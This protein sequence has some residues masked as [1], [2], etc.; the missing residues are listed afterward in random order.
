ML[1]QKSQFKDIAAFEVLV[2]HPETGQTISFKHSSEHDYMIFTDLM[3]SI[4][5]GAQT[6]EVDANFISVYN[7]DQ[8]CYNYFVQRLLGVGIENE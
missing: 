6:D 4:A 2:L 3:N 8:V 7:P 1:L 5:F